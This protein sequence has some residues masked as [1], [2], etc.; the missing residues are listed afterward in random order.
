MCDDDFSNTDAAV[1]CRSLGL[2]TAGAVHKQAFG[3]EAPDSGPIWMDDVNCIGDAQDITL[4]PRLSWGSH[5]CIHWQDVG[6]CCCSNPVCGAASA[7]AQ[8]ATDGC[9]NCAAGKFSDAVGAS[10]SSTCADCGAGKYSAAGASVCIDCVGG[11]F[12]GSPL[13]TSDV[14]TDCAAGKYSAAG[15]TVC[16]DCA[17]GKFKATSGVNAE[18]DNCAA[19]T[20]AAAGAGRLSVFP[21][22]VRD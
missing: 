16:T 18:C 9:G 19:G 11:K 7:A 10:V 4:C 21:T 6:V 22:H 5:N 3:A 20:Y 12:F 17:A 13:Q 14:C 1:A 8:L 15:A 2:P